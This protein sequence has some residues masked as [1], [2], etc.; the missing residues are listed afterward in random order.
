M[1]TSRENFDKVI[2]FISKP[3]IKEMVSWLET[4]TDYF[5]A[6]ASSTFHGNFEGGLLAHSLNVVKFGLHN[7]NL[8]V[9][10][11]P[12]LEYLRE[13]VIIVGLFHDLCKLNIYVKKEKW[14]KD[15]QNKWQSYQD[16]AVDDKLPLGHGEK[17]LYIASKHISLTDA[18]AMAIRWHMGATEFSVN[19]TGSP[20]YYAYYAALTHPL[21][22]LMHAADMLTLT[23][24]EHIDYKNS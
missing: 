3:G 8:L 22:R 24:E 13:S 12:E 18:E 16:W 4:E 10:E 5:T 14:K 6:P 9:K 21:V 7:F 20:Q 17:S 1:A 11:K 19:I 23:I 15:D 2:T